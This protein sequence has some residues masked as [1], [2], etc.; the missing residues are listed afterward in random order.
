MLLRESTRF[1][2]K[3]S[4][5]KAQVIGYLSSQKK[6]P[7]FQK[8]I[9]SKALSFSKCQNEKACFSRRGNRRTTKWK[10]STINCKTSAE[11]QARFDHF[12][13][14]KPCF[15]FFVNPFIVNVVSDGCPICQPF[16]TNVS[17][18]ETKLTGSKKTLVNDT[19]QLISGHRFQK[20]PRIRKT[21]VQ[22]HSVYSTT[23]CCDFFLCDEVRTIKS[24][25]SPKNEHLGEL[26]RTALTKYCLEFRG[27]E[28]KTKTWYWQLLYIISCKTCILYRTC[29]D[30]ANC[31]CGLLVFLVFYKWLFHW[32]SS[33]T[34]GL[35]YV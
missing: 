14:L 29:I 20:I 6:I 13:E 30:T 11:F 27:L 35:Y 28:D 5:P 7:F 22:L 33:P 1:D 8:H 17:A 34:P 26:M 32:T 9:L 25:C 15:A 19:Q 23:Y 31:V 16:V 3:D 18:V 2:N 24:S 21:S 12:Q 10:N 4:E